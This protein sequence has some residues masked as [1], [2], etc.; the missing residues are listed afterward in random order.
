MIRRLRKRNREKGSVLVEFA[1]SVTTI[2]MI[3]FLIIDLGRALYAYNWLCDTARRGTRFAMVRGT[4]CDPYLANYCHTD[5]MPRGA[6]AADIETYVR[7]LNVGIDDGQ[8]MVHSHC[9]VGASVASNPPCAA[10]AWVQV[11]LAYQF[12][13]V[14][15]LF[16]SSVHWMMTAS[17]ERPVQ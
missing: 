9:F 4:V 11:T 13:F 10:P 7:S 16:P 2:L 6:Q 12:K 5:S 3:L 8:L 14:S 17:S 1:L 15:P